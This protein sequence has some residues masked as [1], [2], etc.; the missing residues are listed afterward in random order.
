MINSMQEWPAV[1]VMTLVSL[2]MLI[3]LCNMVGCS[4]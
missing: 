3:T 1:K 4:I 2:Q